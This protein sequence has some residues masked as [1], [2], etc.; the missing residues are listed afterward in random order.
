MALLT[1]RST[2]FPWCKLSP[3]EL[4]MGRRTRSNIPLLKQ[5][6]NPNW[7]YLEDFCTN[8]EK[9]KLKQKSNYDRRHRTKSLSPL[10][11]KSEAWIT[12]DAE[13][14]RGTVVSQADFPRSYIV[15][16]PS[17]PI[18]RNRGH[19]NAVPK[20]AEPPTQSQIQPRSPIMTHTRT[21]TLIVPPDR[22]QV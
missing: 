15:E 22:L 2:P 12:N 16:T 7:E 13:P 18:R 21:G 1:Y 9:F 5:H 19:L 10:P 20:V 14:V 8:N 4:L 11:A 3:S 17:G 6:L